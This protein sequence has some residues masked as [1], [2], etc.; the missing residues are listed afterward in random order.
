VTSVL[1][2]AGSRNE[3]C[4]LCEEAGVASKG[5]ISLAGVRMIDHVLRAVR[6]APELT[7]TVWVTGLS[8]E[9]IKASLPAD[10]TDFVSRVRQAPIGKGPAAAM[11]ATLEN[12]AHLPLL[13]TTCDHPLLTPAMLKNFVEQANEDDSDFSVGLAARPVIDAA[14]PEVKRTY[15][16]LAGRD[17]SGCNLFYVATPLGRKVVSFWRD[18]GRDRKNPL[19]SARFGKGLQAWVEPRGGGCY[20]G[21]YPDCRSSYRC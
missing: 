21:D 8:L 9:T 19:R 10:L 17:Y 5:L 12:G 6:D 2:L 1:I 14:Y 11:L 13:V 20:A 3:T 18:I 16:K 15:I 4:K 7:G